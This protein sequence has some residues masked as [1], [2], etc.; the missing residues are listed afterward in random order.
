MNPKSQSQSPEIPNLRLLSTSITR[1]TNKS[2]GDYISFHRKGRE[3]LL[4]KSGSHL[5]SKRPG[6]NHT[7]RLARTRPEYDSEPVQIV[8]SRTGMHHLHGA[9][10]EPEGHGP[11]RSPTGPVHQ[12]IYLG[13]HELRRLRET[14]RRSGGRRRAWSG[15]GSRCRRGG[16]SGKRCV[17]VRDSGC[18]AVRLEEEREARGGVARN[19]GHFDFLS[20][21]WSCDNQASLITFTKNRYT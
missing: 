20:F 12:V 9:A 14:R 6:D 21:S 18:G 10:G 11:D 19:H 15:V 8:A 5:V 17:E 7:I 16:E 13:D 3:A 2:S 4:A 1:Q